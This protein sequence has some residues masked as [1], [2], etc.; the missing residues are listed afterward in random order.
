MAT[1]K[2]VVLAKRPGNGG[3]IIEG[4]TFAI[5]E[6]PRISEADLKDGQIEIQ[7]LYLSLDPAMRMWLN[8]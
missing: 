2:T 4:E 1:F 7:S 5:K 8:G 6:V 3:P